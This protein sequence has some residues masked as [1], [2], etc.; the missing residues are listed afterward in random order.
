MITERKCCWLCARQSTKAAECITLHLTCQQVVGKTNMTGSTDVEI[1]ASF[2]FCSWRVT[3]RLQ[4]LKLHSLATLQAHISSFHSCF[5]CCRAFELHLEL[6][7]DL[8]PELI[9]HFKEGSTT[10]L[11][12]SQNI[13]RERLVNHLICW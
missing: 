7:A 12:I 3:I 9:C 10:C 6:E 4:R 8:E 1:C 2:F 5:Y 13:Y 11:L